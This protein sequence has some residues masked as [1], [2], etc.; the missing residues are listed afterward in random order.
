MDIQV[1]FPKEMIDQIKEIFPNDL[2]LAEA[3]DSND[4]KAWE[5]L[6]D[7]QNKLA[8]MFYRLSL[9]LCPASD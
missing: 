8:D 4:P 7:K 1:K 5:I 6:R 2:E 9:S 3:L